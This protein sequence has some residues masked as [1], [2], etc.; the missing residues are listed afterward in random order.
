MPIHSAIIETEEQKLQPD[1]CVFYTSSTSWCPV[2]LP[3]QENHTEFSLWGSGLPQQLLQGWELI[4]A[5]ERPGGRTLFPSDLH[6]NA[7]QHLFWI[8]NV[9][10][11][12]SAY[13]TP[14]QEM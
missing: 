8:L 3:L 14:N 13:T 1:L 4:K 5:A 9:G 10:K 11:D 2:V 7:Q 6:A 12:S